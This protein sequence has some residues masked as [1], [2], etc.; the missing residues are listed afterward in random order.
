[1]FT[2]TM[3]GRTETLN[4]KQGTGCE[5]KAVLQRNINCWCYCAIDLLPSRHS[6]GPVQ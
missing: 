2:N 1:M 3:Q 6:W 4:N 5:R